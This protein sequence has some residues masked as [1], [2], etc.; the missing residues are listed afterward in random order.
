MKD[1]V[2]NE[3]EGEIRS[4][5]VI[6]TEGIHT[7][8]IVS[9]QLVSVPESKSGRAYFKWILSTDEGN[10]NMV[11]TLIKKKRWLLKQ[12][13][14]ACR[15]EAIPN[16]LESRYVFEEK[17]VIGKKIKIRVC[18]DRTPFIS[19]TTGKEIV[20]P[21]SVVKEVSIFTAEDITQEETSKDVPF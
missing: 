3:N 8:V 1:E 17:D 10:V 5:N 18:T 15:I 19:N 6:L 4:K 13:F 20:I 21:K 7:A 14:L 11:T 16:D 9:V 12:I 2:E